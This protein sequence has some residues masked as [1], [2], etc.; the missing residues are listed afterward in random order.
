MDTETG[1]MVIHFLSEHLVFGYAGGMLMLLP[2]VCG[3][4]EGDTRSSGLKWPSFR[5][6]SCQA[7]VT[8]HARWGA[9]R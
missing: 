4:S 2:V 3:C 7:D 9:L 1:G 5:G 8:A 6:L